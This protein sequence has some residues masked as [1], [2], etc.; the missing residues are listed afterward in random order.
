M[1]IA[2]AISDQPSLRSD[3]GRKVV[4]VTTEFSLAVQAHTPPA[5]ANRDSPAELTTKATNSVARMR[6]LV[7]I[8]AEATQDLIRRPRSC[9][10]SVVGRRNGWLNRRFRVAPRRAVAVAMTAVAVFAKTGV[11]EGPLPRRIS[12]IFCGG[13]RVT[14]RFGRARR[15]RRDR[16]QCDRGGRIS[17]PTKWS[18]LISRF[19][20][21][22]RRGTSFFVS[23][24]RRRSSTKRRS[25][26]GRATRCR[27]ETHDCSR[28]REA[29]RATGS[30]RPNH[31]RRRA[32]ARPSAM[33]GCSSPTRAR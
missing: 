4:G 31:R 24:G 19:A 26:A 20:G 32:A 29:G 16:G 14:R 3:S 10:C 25:S 11:Q 2:A 18:S 13:P 23:T 1:P 15:A 27:S 5:P 9:R 17:C 8:E 7:S 6:C 22:S 33:I 30:R 21:A 12:S 28:C